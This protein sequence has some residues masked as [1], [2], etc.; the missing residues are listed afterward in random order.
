MRPFTQLLAYYFTY[1]F[2]FYVLFLEIFRDPFQYQ[3][4]RKKELK[5]LNKVI[6]ICHLKIRSGITFR[7]FQFL[8]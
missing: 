6:Y 5:V 1:N 2:S 3:M 8:F 4:Q 7:T